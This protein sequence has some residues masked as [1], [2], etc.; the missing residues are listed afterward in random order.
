MGKAKEGGNGGYGM[1]Q[2]LRVFEMQH[3]LVAGVFSG[4]GRLA[5]CWN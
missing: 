5:I 3:R 2:Y 1:I 4:F